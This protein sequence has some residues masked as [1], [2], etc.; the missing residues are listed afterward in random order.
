MLNQSYANSF[1]YQ[2]LMQRAF[3]TVGS[4]GNGI[5]NSVFLLLN[6]IDN[7]HYGKPKDYPKQVAKIKTYLSKA[8]AKVLKWKLTVEEQS[9]VIHYSQR[10]Q[11]AF[12]ED[13]LFLVIRGLLDSTQRFQ[14]Y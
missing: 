2:A 4:T 14:E 3:R 7:G 10:L 5:H 1:S 8:I 11:D 12:D 9:G 6:Q 13:S